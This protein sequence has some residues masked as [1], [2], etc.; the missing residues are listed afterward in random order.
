MMPC[1]EIQ[2]RQQ[3]MQMTS[4]LK[5]SVTVASYMIEGNYLSALTQYS[6]D[7]GMAGINHLLLIGLVAQMQKLQTEGIAR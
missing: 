1:T 4:N 5:V 7:E 3:V 2:N 6:Q